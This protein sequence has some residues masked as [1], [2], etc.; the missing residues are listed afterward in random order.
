[1]ADG[2]DVDAVRLKLQAEYEDTLVNPY[3]AAER[4]YVDAVIPPWHTR[5]QVWQALRL[6]D[7]KVVDVPAKKHGN[8]PLCAAGQRTRRR[9]AGRPATRPR[10]PRRSSRSPGAT[11][12]PS[13]SGSSPRSSRPP[14]AMPPTAT[15][16][17]RRSG[18]TGGLSR[19]DCARSS[20][21]T[22]TRSS[23][24]ARTDRPRE[25]DDVRRIHERGRGHPP[26]P[27]HRQGRAVRDPPAGLDRALGRDHKDR[28]LRVRRGP[29]TPGSRRPPPDPR[30]TPAG[31]GGVRPAGPHPRPAAGRDRPPDA[32]TAALGARARAHHVD[33]HHAAA[34][35][36]SPATLA[37]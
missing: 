36:L 27:G 3:V 12:P 22:P 24:S 31:A 26:R 14:R 32:A 33:G 35:E 2:E 30:P 19:I 5:L 1:A 34:P 7:R 20:G 9:P 25:S 29:R 4:G 23:T 17:A 13:R 11:R 15:R 37:R 8:V 28:R 21:T 18:T 16:A 6:L 10:R